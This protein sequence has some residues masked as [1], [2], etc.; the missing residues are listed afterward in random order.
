[1]PKHNLSTFAGQR[2]LWGPIAIPADEPERAD[3][4]HRAGGD[5]R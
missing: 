3:F 2:M 4:P 1:M 5:T